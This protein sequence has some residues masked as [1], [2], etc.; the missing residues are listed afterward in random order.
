MDDK[1]KAI[2]FLMLEKDF[3][4]VFEYLQPHHGFLIGAWRHIAK[5][6]LRSNSPYHHRYSVAIK[7]MEELNGKNKPN[8]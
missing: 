3:N 8:G 1:V 7:L 4:G 5:Y 2:Y 6:A